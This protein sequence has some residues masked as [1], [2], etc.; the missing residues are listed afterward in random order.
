MQ[1][2]ARAPAKVNLTL[3]V[4]GRRPDG[5]HE[6][7]S[8]VAFAGCAVD[9]VTL[10][11]GSG[12]ALGAVDGPFADAAGPD[13]DNLVLKAARAAA[14]RIE[15]LTLG[16]FSLVKRIPVAAGLGGGSADAGAALRL[17]A[18]ANGLASDD[19][20]LVEAAAATGSD[21]P[22]CLAS[23]A[24]RMTG[25]GEG[26]SHVDL[27]PMAAVLA[28]P[29]KGLSTAEVFRALGLAPGARA[30]STSTRAPTRDGAGAALHLS[31]V[32]R[33][34]P[35]G[36]GEGA[37]RFPENPSPPHPLG[38]A[39]RPLPTGERW[40]AAPVFRD[41]LAGAGL[42]APND[43]EPPARALMP[44]IGQGIDAVAATEG[45]RL[46]R[47]SGSGATVFGLYDD[48]RAARRAARALKAILP[49]WWI[50]PSMLR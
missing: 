14:D 18:E 21:V 35:E 12:L 25:R 46:A 40:A 11:Q 41:L 38:F 20:R 23:R 17:I 7:D 15:G 45:C 43:L 27:P 24:A 4:L 44:E 26:I 31:P 47:M 5:F 48:Q 10:A 6:L 34:R 16:T 37:S 13:D 22:A 36:P 33:G 30:S 9:V 42:S 39:S 28:N 29:L 2:R 49:G 50:R 8:V 1:L 32:G 3:R 19:P